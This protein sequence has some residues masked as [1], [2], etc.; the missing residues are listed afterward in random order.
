LARAAF[1]VAEQFG[2][3]LT[4][5]DIGGGF[6]GNDND[7]RVSFPQIAAAITPVLEELFPSYIEVIGEP[8]R[9]MASETHSLATSLCSRRHIEPTPNDKAETLRYLYYINDGVYGSF[10]CIFFDHAHP[11][12]IPLAETNAPLVNCKIFGPT[13]DSMDVV[14]ESYPLPELAIGDWLYFNSMGAYTS[15]SSSAFN[16][17][18]TRTTFYVY[19]S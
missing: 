3:C 18:K 6:P 10:N 12:P 17:F 11:T 8:G 9:Y 2:F 14:A 15:S 1:D 5:L 7:S 13:C 4:L 16:G 19:T